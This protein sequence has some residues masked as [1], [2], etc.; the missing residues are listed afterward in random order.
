MLK[1]MTARQR[2]KIVE[3]EIQFMYDGNSGYSF[4]CDERGNLLPMEACAKENY[5]YCLAHPEEFEEWNEQVA[6]VRYVTD[7]ATGTCFC[8][9]TVELWDQYMGACKC[10]GCDRWYNLFGQQLNPPETWE[11]GDDW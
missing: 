11:D 2:R 10:P 5:D 4:P 1:N 3:H 8:G 7:N 9:A 6:I